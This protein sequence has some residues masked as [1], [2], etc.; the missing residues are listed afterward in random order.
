MEKT[1]ICNNCKVEKSINEFHRHSHKK[2][3]H[4][5]VCKFC[6][7]ILEADK[8][9]EYKK[10]NKDKIASAG[11][12]YYIKNKEKIKQYN[13]ENKIKIN[14]ARSLYKKE[15]RISDPS[16]KLRENISCLFRHFLK[17][18][19]NIKNNSFFK[20]CGYTIDIYRMRL[21]NTFTS[22]MNWDN[23]GEF[24]H[25]DHII[26][27]ASFNIPSSDHIIVKI[28]W[29]PFNLRALPAKQ[30]ISENCRPINFQL[31]RDI[32]NDIDHNINII[33]IMRLAKI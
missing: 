31:L 26:S 8:Q 9:K 10:N 23:Y 25:I 27:L 24:W 5:E 15:K 16:F 20:Y 22:E 28:L 14:N 13:K 2:D 30:N 21:E 7:S 6:R 32:I 18:S 11:A 33:D 29:H 19:K 1:K 3:G 12:A 17:K 4:R